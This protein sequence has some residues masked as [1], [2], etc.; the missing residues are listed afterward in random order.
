MTKMN[1]DICAP[2]KYDSKNDTCFTI[3][4]LMEMARAYNRYISKVK[5]SPKKMMEIG[6]AELIQITHDKPYLLNEFR[7]RFKT[8]CDESELCITQQAFMKEIVDEMH[9]DIL[10]G[11]IRPT[12]PDN[13]KEW[14]STNDINAIMKQYENVYDDF[15]FFG[16][17][18]LNCNELSFCSLFKLNFDKYEKQRINKLG[19]IF[20]LDKYGEP[21]SHWV[22][23]FIDIAA[24]EIYF[25]DSMGHEPTDNI[26]KIIEQFQKFYKKKTG[27]DAIY[28]YNTHSYQ[29]DGSECGVY[30]CNFIIRKLAGETFKQIVE[31]P[32]AFKQINSCRNVYFSNKPSKFEPNEYCD[33]MKK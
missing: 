22:A 3:E 8:I 7:T 30:S 19:I 9:D 15:K 23:L 16:A 14:L 10:F 26:K 2:R 18:P 21:G 17:V 33:P 25:C 12:G 5:L 13:P 27:K 31:K 20:N 24:G 4:Q 1:T 11:T 6:G 28:E 29:K 32:L